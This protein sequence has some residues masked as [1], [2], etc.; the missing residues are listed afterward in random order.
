MLQL[1]QRKIPRTTNTQRT[2]N[3]GV[4]LQTDIK[5]VYFTGQ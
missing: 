2:G 5:W 3:S 1:V 4:N